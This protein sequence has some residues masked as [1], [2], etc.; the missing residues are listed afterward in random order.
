M[1]VCASSASIHCVARCLA[2]HR[3]TAAP[4]RCQARP[5]RAGRISCRR[6]SSVCCPSP[7]LHAKT[8]FWP[9]CRVAVFPRFLICSSAAAAMHVSLSANSILP[10]SSAHT[11]RLSVPMTFAFSGV[12]ISLR[13]LKPNSR[14]ASSPTLHFRCCLADKVT[15]PFPILDAS[16][17]ASGSPSQRAQH[18]RELLDHLRQHGFVRLKNT[19]IPTQAIHEAFAL[20]STTHLHS[21]LD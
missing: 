4:A 9:S 7:W 3:C 6:A 17:F 14:H 16:R 10:P 8:M 18:A 19:G 1:P 21:A 5:R 11:P 13:S 15:M 2:T 12:F 20:V